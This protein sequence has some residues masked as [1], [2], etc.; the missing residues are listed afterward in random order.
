M[1]SRDISNYYVGIGFPPILLI[2]DE[3]RNVA[4][5]PE[6][7]DLACECRGAGIYIIGF[8]QYPEKKLL[9]A[10]IAANMAV[11][12]CLKVS[13]PTE[14]RTILDSP[15]SADIV[16][17][18]EFYA[19]SLIPGKTGLAHGFAPLLTDTEINSITKRCIG[20]PEVVKEKTDSDRLQ[21]VI[22]MYREAGDDVAAI[23]GKKIRQKLGCGSD[24]AA[25]LRD[26]AYIE[27]GIE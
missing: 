14:S 5:I 21:E 9:G 17:K 1:E 16:N 8:T 23:S 19:K 7:E 24:A 20:E 18:G 15:L 27:L 10:Q 25:R 3:M 11:R 6:L 22:A 26:L 4:D 13:T 12:I 2:I